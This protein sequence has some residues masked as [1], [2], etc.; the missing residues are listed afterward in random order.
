MSLWPRTLSTR[1]IQ[2]STFSTEHIPVT[3]T[4][5]QFLSMAT[6]LG[7]TTLISGPQESLTLNQLLGFTGSSNADTGPQ[8]VTSKPIVFGYGSPAMPAWSPESPPV[9]ALLRSPS[10]LRTSVLPVAW[11]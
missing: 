7:T 10:G 1:T 3:T 5:S 9:N 8:M 11:G 6:P 4:Y 2:P